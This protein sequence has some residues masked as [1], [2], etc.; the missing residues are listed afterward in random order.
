M[1]EYKKADIQYLKNILK[2]N[3][4]VEMLKDKMYRWI[5]YVLENYVQHVQQMVYCLLLCKVAGAV[6]GGGK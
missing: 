3:T 6:D 1:F 2:N 4:Y 5:M